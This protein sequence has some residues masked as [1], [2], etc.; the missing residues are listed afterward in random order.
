MTAP[1]PRAKVTRIVGP[2]KGRP[3]RQLR[4]P[5]RTSRETHSD[6]LRLQ[7]RE[8]GAGRKWRDAEHPRQPHQ[9]LEQTLGRHHHQRC[10]AAESDQGRAAAMSC[11]LAGERENFGHVAEYSTILCV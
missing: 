5:A 2:T 10:T 8:D 1:S 7:P 4:G 9:T 3:Q 11:L 6:V